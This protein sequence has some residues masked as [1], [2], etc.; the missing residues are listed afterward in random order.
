MTEVDPMSLLLECPVCVE[1]MKPPRKI[2]QCSNG[3]IICEQCKKNPAVKVCPTCRVPMR[4][5]TRNIFAESV[6]EKRAITLNSEKSTSIEAKDAIVDLRAL[7][8]DATILFNQVTSNYGLYRT[9]DVA[10]RAQM[11]VGLEYLVRDF[12]SNMPMHVTNPTFKDT[13]SDSSK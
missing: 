11:R 10:H 1:V 8:R 2:F 5:V 6:A 4:K 7:K 9:I 3:H 12:L 13:I